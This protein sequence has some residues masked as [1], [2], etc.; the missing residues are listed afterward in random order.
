MV[1]YNQP[2]DEVKVLHFNGPHKPWY[3]IIGYGDIYVSYAMVYQQYRRAY[4]G[5]LQSHQQR[6]TMVVLV[7]SD[8]ALQ[9]ALTSITNQTYT[10]LDI[11]L[12]NRTKN[13]GVRALLK[14]W[15]SYDERA[16]LLDSGPIAMSSLLPIVSSMSKGDY[17][18]FLQSSDYVEVGL[19]EESLPILSE[20]TAD[21]LLVEYCTLDCE[22]GIYRFPDVVS[23]KYEELSREE[24]LTTDKGSRFQALWG[25]WYRREWLDSLYILEATSEIFISHQ[26]YTSS[27]KNVFLR[28]NYFCHRHQLPEAAAEVR[29]MSYYRTALVE[30][31]LKLADMVLH[32][33]DYTHLLHQMKVLIEETLETCDKE[34]P[35]FSAYLRNK[36]QQINHKI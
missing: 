28:G 32:H 12:V 14:K 11:L 10:N 17:L 27:Q 30:L 26:T 31:D 33:L 9:D 7:D 4:Q 20:K 16:T 24:L 15:T 19:V 25:K 3:P 34:D 2:V 8:Y 5:L 22:S 18:F 6:L 36:L 29:N 13:D 21:I 35:N 23:E 1:Q